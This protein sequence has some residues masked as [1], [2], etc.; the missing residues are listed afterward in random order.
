LGV[1]TPLP[2]FERRLRGSRERWAVIGSGELG[3]KAEGLLAGHDILAGLDG[4]RFAPLVTEIPA[5]TVVATSAF[6]AFLERNRL[7]EVVEEIASDR[8]LA[9]AFQRAALPTEVLGDLWD[10]IRHTKTPLAVRSSSLL[11]DA[12]R[13]PFA[14]IYE[15]KMIPNNQPEADSRFRR[16]TEAIKFVYAST[17]RTR[18]RAYQRAIG[19]DPH[20]E[21][22]AL[23]L[24]EVVGRRHGVRFYPDVSGV[25]RSW[26]FY[27]FGGAD[28]RD[29]AVSLALGLGKTIVDGGRSWTYSPGRPHTAPPHGSPS[30]LL[31]QAQVDFWAVNMG[32]APAYDPTAETEYLVR[33]GLAEAE[34]DGSLGHVASTYVAHSDAIVPGIARDGARL[35][36]FA[37][38]L[39]RNGVPLNETVTAILAACA[40]AIGSDVEIEFAVTLPSTREE[41]PRFALLQVRPMAVSHGSVEIAEGELQGPRV[42]VS[43]DLVMGNGVVEGIR[44]FVLVR[45]SSFDPRHSRAIAA[46]LQGV[47]RALQDEG[48]PYIL[49][50]FG[51]WG[52]S[53][54][55]LGV[56][57]DWAQVSAARVI[58]EARLSGF[59]VEMSQGAHLFQNLMAFDVPYFSAGPGEGEAVR[60][61]RILALPVHHEGPFIRHVRCREPFLVKVDGRKGRGVIVAPEKAA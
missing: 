39:K 22:M 46:E 47:N 59:S 49:V 6:D 25:A 31:D 35:V 58:V 14:G 23:V 27:A 54:P 2:R 4:S 13:H 55:W 1:A 21:K 17:F 41:A 28:P 24:Q 20:D 29:G 43:S 50:G 16:L 26:N 52:S 34:A 15:T 33:A 38:L 48:R 51:R 8:A 37:P 57:V 19:R 3:G 61:E 56:P 36:D 44:D 42:L 53:D 32:P 9:D 10:L 30:E 45:P 60:W 12:L 7:G 40:D 18:A 5:L 11:E